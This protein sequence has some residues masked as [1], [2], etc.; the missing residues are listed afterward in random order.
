MSPEIVS[1]ILMVAMFIV[2]SF[3]P[4]NLGA[5]AFVAAWL[6]GSLGG[7]SA[8][9]IFAGFPGDLFVL[10]IGVTYLFAIAQRNGTVGWL[11]ARGMRMVGG[12]VAAIPWLMFLLAGILTSVG[13]LSAA[14]VAIVAPI[15]LRFAA[16]YRVNSLLMGIMVVQGVTA[17]SFSPMSPFGAITGE[18]VEKAGLA[19][20]PGLLFANS[21]VFNTLVAVV[22]FLALGGIGLVRRGRIS[23]EADESGHPDFVATGGS[24]AAAPAVG[25][26]SRG[27]EKPQGAP[28]GTAV[29]VVEHEPTRSGL[30]AHQSATLAGIVLLIIGAL[31]FDLDV[32]FLALAVAIALTLATPHRLKGAI[33][34]LPWPVILL[35][36][37]ILTYVAV[38]EEIGTI[39][40]I[41][42]LITGSGNGLA[43]SLASSYIGGVVSAF[44][45]TAGVLGATIPLAVPVLSES[46]LPVMGVVS[47]I[48]ISSS[49]V[50]ASPL[51]TNGALLLA[52]QKTMDE[53]VFFRQLLLY[54]IVI[55]VA[56]PLLAWLIFVV[57]Q[58]P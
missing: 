11:T 34:D 12:R 43:A 27:P 58:V 36:S 53:R 8:D 17:G 24:E 3:L 29:G 37:G 23:T 20:S 49:I 51:S 44:A 52:N 28:S 41:G 42:D 22:V 39:A 32:G 48:A 50:D 18:V 56:A 13:A 16:Q 46:A 45:A 10:L 6:V 4:V 55:V 33:K 5:L 25:A 40:Y 9:D 38:L 30:S 57:L 54:A 26:A 47:A 7:M 15:A 21:I 1:I 2:A 35:I 31:W 14:G 19:H